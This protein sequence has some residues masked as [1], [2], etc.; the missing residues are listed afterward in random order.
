M[1]QDVS[2]VPM[3]TIGDHT[4]GVTDTF[5]Y[6]GSKISSNLSLDAELSS[7]IGKASSTMA[8]LSKRVWENKKLTINTKVK[9]YH[10][11]VLSTLLYGSEAWTLYSSQE[12][13]LN[14]FHMRCLR[15][16][17][18]ITWQDRIRN[19]DILERAGTRSMQC[20]LKQKRLHW[21]GHIC[22]MEDGRIPKDLLFGE[23]ATGARPTGRPSLRFKDVCKRDLKDC[24]INP[25]DL[26]AATSIRSSWR[27]TT[28]IGSRQAEERKTSQMRKRKEERKQQ[29]RSQTNCNPVF[30]CTRCGRACHSRIGLYSH[31]RSYRG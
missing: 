28:K 18:G 15:R 12:R 31:S 29:P 13:K 1:G 8:R 20:I 14:T 23:L 30:T 9:V 19:E 6:L 5:T 4:L 3:I 17:L 26:Q 25:A 2:Q 11:C 27:T 22:R 24:A 7:R 10:S 21:L 16:L